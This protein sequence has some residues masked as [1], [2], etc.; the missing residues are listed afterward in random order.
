MSRLSLIHCHHSCSASLQTAAAEVDLTVAPPLARR[1][2]TPGAK[3]PIIWVTAEIA[4]FY[5]V[6]VWEV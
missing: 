2:V 4:S 1:G 6:S 3:L 5:Q